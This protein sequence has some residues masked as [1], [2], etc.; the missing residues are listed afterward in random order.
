M[1]GDLMPGPGMILCGD[2]TTAFAQW[3]GHIEAGRIGA[4]VGVE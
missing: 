2:P 4:K 1:A 3:L